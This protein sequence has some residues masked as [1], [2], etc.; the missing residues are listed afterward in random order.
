M[1]LLL[2]LLLLW[3]P[4]LTPKEC[5]ELAEAAP[6][7]HEKPPQ[8]ID[9]DHTWGPGD[10]AVMKREFAMLD[11]S[12]DGFVDA[13][14]RLLILFVVKLPVLPHIKILMHRACVAIGKVQCLRH[15]SMHTILAEDIGVAYPRRVWHGVP[16]RQQEETSYKCAGVRDWNAE[17]LGHNASDKGPEA[18]PEDATGVVLNH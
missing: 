1:L 16:G 15:A 4:Y 2:Q 7:R 6:S 12:G 9:E 8:K 18:I 14:V 5:K 3:Y 10:I 11:T 13:L 17:T